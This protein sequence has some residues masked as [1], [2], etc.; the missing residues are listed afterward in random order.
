MAEELVSE[1][2]L[3]YKK[4]ASAKDAPA[5]APVEDEEKVAT[6]EQPAPVEDEEEVQG[7]YRQIIM[8]GAFE[9]ETL[10]KW[11]AA[12]KWAPPEDELTYMLM[13]PGGIARMAIMFKEY[14]E[15]KV[16]K[17]ALVG[18]TS[19]S[20][21]AWFPFC[22]DRYLRLCYP[23]TNWWQHSPMHTMNR[24]PHEQ[25]LSELPQ[26]LELSS[27]IY[28]M[29]KNSV[30][31]TK[32][33]TDEIVNRDTFRMNGI[34]ALWL[35]ERGMVDGVI[36]REL[37]PALWIVLTR[38][39]LKVAQCGDKSDNIRRRVLCSDKTLA[40]YGLTQF[41][42]IKPSRPVLSAELLVPRTNGAVEVPAAEEAK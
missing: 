29:I 4:A 42:P 9:N 3:S 7:N 28:N 38:E 32:E 15:S 31:L 27:D 16:N 25:V 35:G 23:H 12:D 26:M 20:S 10:Y 2:D 30:G 40:K 18:M 13:S 41:V 17:I 39:G 21:A 6:T 8:H 11:L 33:E 5:P 1:W 34:D 37:S 22:T 14:L 19:L 24:T 36:Y